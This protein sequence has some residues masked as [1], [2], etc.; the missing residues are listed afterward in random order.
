MPTSSTRS[1][2][3]A[4]RKHRQEQNL[5][6]ASANTTTSSLSNI[7]GTSPHP[8]HSQPPPPYSQIDQRATSS[9]SQLSDLSVDE[10][11]GTQAESLLEYSDTSG[12]EREDAYFLADPSSRAGGSRLLGDDPGETGESAFREMRAGGSKSS[13]VVQ[14]SSNGSS[15]SSMDFMRTSIST[16]DTPPQPPMSTP[17]PAP[18]PGFNSPALRKWVTNL[19]YSFRSPKV[20]TQKTLNP[21]EQR[22]RSQS[23]SG[24]MEYPYSSSIAWRP[25]HG[26]FYSSN[27]SFYM[28]SMGS[29]GPWEE[30]PLV[31]N[32]MNEPT[33]YGLQPNGYSLP[34]HSLKSANGNSSD[35]GRIDSRPKHG[36]LRSKSTA[37][38]VSAFFLLDY[39]AGRPPTLSPNFEMITPLQL[40]IYRVHFFWMWRYFGVNLAVLVLFLAHSRNRLTTALMHT[41]SILCLF[42]EVWMREQLYG[43][44][45]DDDR[46]HT[47][48]RLNRP[49]I[50]FLL[51][52]GLESWVW[53][54]FPPDPLA[55]VP[56]LVSSVFKPV[57]F[58]YVSH[59]ARHALEGLSRI[60]RI[61]ARVLMIEMF[62]ILAFAA[63]AC[64]LYR[65]YESFKNLS[66]AWL[67]LFERKF[68]KFLNCMFSVACGFEANSLLNHELHNL[69]STTVVN[70]SLWMPMYEVSPSNSIFFIFFI[71]VS[72]FYL[73]SLVLSVVFQTYIHAAT[74]IH[75][76]SVADREEAIRQSFV[77]LMRDEKSDFISTSSVRKA[78]QIV[79]PHYSSLK[80]REGSY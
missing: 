28:N 46:F 5:N 76:R 30:T 66:S 70:P 49:L 68:S 19:A 60:T 32:G 13:R 72:V 36:A 24:I 21:H 31:S 45:V 2:R 63:V 43:Q 29:G 69:V 9:N 44:E 17:H 27:S 3:Q 54:I 59:K 25:Y 18:H 52:L 40:R 20:A 73:H 23:S 55:E 80:V 47:E 12:E 71:I 10:Y 58:F 74:E 1:Q 61:V 41:F 38:T 65:D 64:Q 42:V 33:V 53:Y 48:R 78:L 6:T 16:L 50:L 22:H 7:L 77:A 37:A 75:E 8:Y 35:R 11:S 26:H 67:S 14:F 79:R 39:E 4:Q 57:V 62:L 34:N 15:T 51:I 56:A